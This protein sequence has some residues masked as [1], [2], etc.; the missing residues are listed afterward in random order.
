M[1][2]ENLIVVSD[3]GCVNGGNSKVAI[4]T[5]LAI[6]EKEINVSFFCGTEPIDDELVRRSVDIVC[7]Q[8][9]DIYEGNNRVKGIVQGIWNKKAEKSFYDNYK[10]FNKNTTVVHFHGWL[11]VL[12]ASV[13]YIAAKMGFKIYFTLHDYNLFCPNGSLYIFP[14]NEICNY[15]PLSSKCI[16]CNC[17][18][19]KYIHKLYRVL[20]LLS[21]KYAQHKIQ[22]CY[23]ITISEQNN[24]LCK[25]YYNNV[26]VRMIK[27]P[28]DTTLPERVKV[29]RNRVF[30]F[31]GRISEEKGIRLF[32]EAV[33]IGGYEGIVLGDGYLL[34]ELKSKYKNINFIGWCQKENI[35]AYIKKARALVFPSLWYEGAPLV[36]MEML[37]YGIPCIVS[38]VSSATEEIRDG[39]NGYIFKS[40]NKDDLLKAMKKVMDEQNLEQISINAQNSFVC[41]RIS[42]DLYSEELLEFYR[43]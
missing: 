31:I 41:N 10:A 18:R 28:T 14:K 19:R 32:C 24:R 30:L 9:Q 2:I 38:D 42:M 13:I 39:E 26:H 17:D 21:Q 35:A 6:K 16:L 11:R 8:Q 37:Q 23:L 33:T 15:Q 22:T 34:D 29:E 27:N 5:A 20:R 3:F 25:Q 43:E 12:S 36:I 7:L 1:Q 4:Q 40:N